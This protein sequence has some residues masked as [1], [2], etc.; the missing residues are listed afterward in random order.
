MNKSFIC[1]KLHGSKHTSQLNWTLEIF[2]PHM[3]TNFI[4]KMWWFFYWSR[5]RHFSDTSSHKKKESEE[6]N[7]GGRLLEARW[8]AEKCELPALTICKPPSGATFSSL[9]KIT[10]LM[11]LHNKFR[12]KANSSST[13]QFANVK[14]AGGGG[15]LLLH[16]CISHKQKRAC[17]CGR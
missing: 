6:N 5:D 1:D 12:N 17:V 13:R 11:W 8:K 4:F 16:V 9:V 7:C 10:L 2:L 14:T 3:L 15:E